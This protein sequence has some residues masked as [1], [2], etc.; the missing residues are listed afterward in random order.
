MAENRPEGT[1][2]RS[3]FAAIAGR[4]SVGKSTLLN[5]VVGQKVAI[6]SDKPQTTRNRIAGVLNEPG[7]QVVFVDTPG[8]HKPRHKLGEYMV[9]VA[10]RTL[11]DVDVVL[12]M[13]D[14]STPPGPGDRYVADLLRRVTSPVILV[15]NKIDLLP[16]ADGVLP[17]AEGYASLVNAREVIPASAA[18]GFNV[19]RV[20]EVVAALM[21]EGPM[22]YP[23]GEVTDQPERFIA[24]ELIR[25]KLLL[26]T[27][28]EVP[29]SVAVDVEEMSPRKGDLVYISASVYVERESQK[30]IVI[31]E[32]GRLLKEV[33]R[34]ARLDIEALL[35]NRVYLD[36]WVKVK[37]DWRNTESV[38]RALGYDPRG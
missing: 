29:H 15:L 6:V 25:E 31:G 13:V 19:D 9:T 16:G 11:G 2:F 34:L 18:T 38:L 37:K 23:E 35:G 21:P 17:H 8:I 24:R 28:E 26:L 20:V 33:G 3:G 32:G 10:K 5:R 27:R 7:L 36:L 30:R 1:G 14:G 4:P 22:Y 12:F